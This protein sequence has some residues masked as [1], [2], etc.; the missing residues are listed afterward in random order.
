[1]GK[2]HIF[3]FFRLSGEFSWATRKWWWFP[4]SSK[5]NSHFSRWPEFSQW[6]NHEAW[7][8]IQHWWPHEGPWSSPWCSPWSRVYFTGSGFGTSIWY[9]P[10]WDPHLVLRDVI[11]GC[12]CWALL[13]KLHKIKWKKWHYTGTLRCRLCTKLYCLHFRLQFWANLYIICQKVL[14]KTVK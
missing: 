4:G 1:M 5:P 13:A 9:T 8:H 11:A 12:Y 10:I 2:K 3:L 6:Y 14:E 7:H